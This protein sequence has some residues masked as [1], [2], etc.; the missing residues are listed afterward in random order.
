MTKAYSDE[1]GFSKPTLVAVALVFLL[2]A[3]ALTYFLAWRPSDNDYS[4]AS[5][6]I[7]TLSDSGKAFDKQFSYISKAGLINETT[8]IKLQIIANI[9]KR[10]LDELE[11]SP[12]VGR[13][14]SIRSTYDRHKAI[15][16]EY[17]QSAGNL[18]TSLKLYITVLVNCR[19][20]TE[21]IKKSSGDSAYKDALKK[22]RDAIDK[23]K[24]SDNK[25]FNDQFLTEYLTETE[26][27]IA[28]VDQS[29]GATDIATLM[30]DSDKAN[31]IYKKIAALG[32]KELYFQL[33]NITNALK[34]L[35]LAIDSQK[36]SF[37]R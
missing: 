14:F 27:Y 4:T 30:A 7:T 35:S 17:E 34:D 1:S 3:A 31:E 26:K 16:K 9:Y 5:Q 10:S 22:C 37:W 33:P 6:K 2:I 13:D 18:A 11:K 20:Y 24:A 28:V 23:A 15:L 32:D 19:Q 21:A 25:T 8:G 12:S 29:H 36:K